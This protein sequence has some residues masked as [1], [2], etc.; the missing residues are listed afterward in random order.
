M[1]QLQILTHQ[2][3]KTYA[4]PHFFILNKGLNSGKPLKTSCPNCFVLISNDETEM[5]L[6]YWLVYGL[7]R[8]KSFHPYLKGSVIYFI[9][10]NDLKAVVTKAKITTMSNSPMFEESVNTLKKLEDIEERYLN[11]LKLIQEA[12]RAVFYWYIKK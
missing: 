9:T 11:N 6:N 12:K 8:A 7:W 2:I 1:Q 5:D 4:K 10:I 3:G